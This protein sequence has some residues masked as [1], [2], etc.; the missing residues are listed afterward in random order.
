M[1]KYKKIDHQEKFI[2][3]LLNKIERAVNSGEKLPWIKPWSTSPQDCYS[4]NMTTGNFYSG[5]NAVLLPAGGYITY[6]Q[7]KQHNLRIKKE[8][9]KNY[10][11]CFF[12]TFVTTK[13]TKHLPEKQQE[14]YPIFKTFQVYHFDCL[15]E[16]SQKKAK[17]KFKSLDNEELKKKLKENPPLK[18]VDDTLKD[19]IKTLSGGFKHNGGRAFYRPS[20]DMVN[21]PELVRFN[22]TTSYYSTL[23]HELTH[24][25]GHNSR[26]NRDFSGSFGSITYAKEEL[27]AELGACILCQQLQIDYAGGHIDDAH[28]SIA[29]LQSWLGKLKN[30][31]EELKPALSQAKKAA[32]FILKA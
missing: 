4:F 6:N 19:Y 21:V 17:E 26:L 11:I 1:S 7:A 12:W 14:K 2:T 30:N 27:I 13:E 23:L 9:I 16:E 10:E 20:D 29:Y 18:T 31:V 5:L 15:E 22:D 28:N 3:T 8:C 32:D 24:S 25:T